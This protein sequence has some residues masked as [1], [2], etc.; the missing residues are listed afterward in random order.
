MA[1]DDDPRSGREGASTLEQFVVACQR[2]LARAMWHAQQT[3]KSE[4]GF[5]KGERPLYV[6]QGLDIELNAGMSLDA[7]ADATD[8]VLLDF[9]ATPKRR[10]KVRF[11]VETRPLEM[12]RGA[13]LELAEMN[14]LRGPE[15]IPQFAGWVL[16]TNGRPLSG[17]AV[18]VFAASEGAGSHQVQQVV[19]TDAAGEIRFRLTRTTLDVAGADGRYRS[20]PLNLP[21]P[22]GDRCWVWAEADIADST[23]PPDRSGTGKIGGVPSWRSALLRIRMP[24]ER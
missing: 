22:L 8:G 16:G 2:S 17:H 11:R 5:A 20:I 24:R 23:P 3:S 14:P 15:E 13:K 7:G 10:S 6:V 21:L 4:V 12:E 9:D 19:E 18:R 1:R